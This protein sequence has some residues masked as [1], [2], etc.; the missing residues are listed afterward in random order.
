MEE[1]KQL[2][3]SRQGAKARKVNLSVFFAGFAYFAPLRETVSQ[4]LQSAPTL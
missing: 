3:Q 1:S 2:T 4:P